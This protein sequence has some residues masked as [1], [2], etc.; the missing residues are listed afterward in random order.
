MLMTKMRK[1]MKPIAIIVVLAFA[2]GLL[3]LGLPGGFVGGSAQA[4]VLA[5]VNG[6]VIDQLTFRNTLIQ[7]VTQLEAQNGTLP[8]GQIELVGAQILRQMIDEKL[9]LSA[10]KKAKVTVEQAQI[11]EVIA[12]FTE[13]VGGR[14][15]FEQLLKSQNVS[16]RDF[17]ERIKEQLRIQNFLQQVAGD[18]EVTDEEIARAYEQVHAQHILIATTGD[19]EADAAAE[20]K[21]KEL[22]AKLDQGA[23]FA[24]LAKEY[25]EDPGSKDDGGDLDF[26]S[27]GQT[28]PEFEEAAFALQVGEVSE[29]VKTQFGYHLIKVVARKEAAGEEFEQ[30]KEQIAAQLRQSKQNA[31]LMAWYTEAKSNAKIVINDV[32]LSAY[33]A[34]LDGETEKA[35]DL[36]TQA[37]AKEPDNGYLYAN[38]GE[39]YEVSGDTDKAIANYEK[40]AELVKTDAS[41]YFVIGT[42]YQEKEDTAAAVAAFRKASEVDPDN[43]Y[44]HYSL[45]TI[46]SQMGEED[47]AK[48]EMAVLERIQREAAE[49]A[50][51]AAEEAEKAEQANQ[52]AEAE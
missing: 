41:L 3:Y 13:Q 12:N 11:D 4:S 31:N 19:P 5:T 39:L 38:L 26:I 10:A 1:S 2:A 6:E 8:L 48:E 36:F 35:I 24:A 14:E 50:A 29:P 28:V 21:I 33:N 20:A 25:S 47:L 9:I 30:A 23:D 43:F 7:Y 46:F 34:K 15:S 44:L 22:K 16:L 17:T 45:Y 40:A 49:A 37:I 32:K 51:K 52:A 27:R 18:G 42:L